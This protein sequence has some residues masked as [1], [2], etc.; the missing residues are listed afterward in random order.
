[1]LYYLMSFLSETVSANRIAAKYHAWRTISHSEGYYQET[2]SPIVIDQTRALIVKWQH[3][4]DLLAS[5]LRSIT[6]RSRVP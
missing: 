2:P 6:V 5:Y 1:M 3:Q 4:L